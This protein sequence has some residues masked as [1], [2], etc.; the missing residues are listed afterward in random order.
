M[1]KDIVIGQIV[2]VHGVRGAVKV[3]PLTDRPERFKRTA[4]VYVELPPE[5]P[6]ASALS[7]EYKVC[8]ASVGGDSV[9]LVLEG[10]EDRD[11]AELFR[12][13]MLS[14]PRGKAIKL[15]KDSYFIGDLI[16]CKVYYGAENRLL[17]TVDDVFPTGSNDVYS[18]V[19]PEGKNVYVP[20]IGSVV[21][22]VDVEKA[23][24]FVELLPG[25][26]EV[27]TGEGDEQ[28]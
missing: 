14:V 11:T 25:L 22:K 5:S 20:A 10:I 19:T 23:E 7:G 13:A 12:G 2:S 9:I 15:P 28:N 26:L 27:Y 6:R 16:G 4:S 18:V 8:S 17:G 1:L 24:I 21:K 3:N